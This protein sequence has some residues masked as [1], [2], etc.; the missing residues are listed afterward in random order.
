MKESVGENFM[1]ASFIHVADTHLGYEQYG[2]RER[3]NDF[4]RVFWDITEDAVRRSVDFMVIAGDLF[5][6]RAIDAL[7]LIHAIRGLSKLK[8]RGIPVI[9]IEGNHDRSFYRDGASWLQF[10]C[11]EG[12]IILLNPLMQEGTPVIAPWQRDNMIGAYVDLLEGHLRV[13]GLP[14]QGAS[15]G[16][17]MEGLAKALA[18]ARAEEE[19]SGVEYRLLTMHTGIDGEVPRIQG[20]PT[21]AQFQTLRQHVDYLALGHVHKPYTHDGWIYNP[22]STETCSAEE[23]QWDDRGYY[24]VQIDTEQPENLVGRTEEERLHHAVRLSSQRRPYV[25]HDLR[26]DGL[27]DPDVLYD[28]LEDY[29]HRTSPRYRDGAMQPVVQIHLVGTLGFDAA[30]LDQARM[31]EMVRNYFQPLYVRIDDHTNDRDYVPDE[32]ELDGRDR[33]QWYALERRIFEQLVVSLDDRY[34]PTREQWSVVLAQLKQ[35]ALEDKEP[36]EIAQF[37]RDKRASLFKHTGEV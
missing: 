18:E 30:T 31:E 24:Y 17:S 29:C 33:T 27:S 22:G 7:T 14:W 20:L 21:M 10:L 34:L 2:V 8:E 13:Y 19:T 32:G 36:A 5:N 23:S 3:F 35:F 12:Y 6:K 37:L 25:R 1:R 28:R 11:Y 9:A 15:I 4:S 16:R 26:V